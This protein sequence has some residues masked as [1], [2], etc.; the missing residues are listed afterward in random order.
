MSSLPFWGYGV[1]LALSLLLSLVLT[2]VAMNLAVRLGLL[3]HPGPSK[4]HSKAVPYLGGAAIV[5]SFAVIVLAATA[6]RPPPTGF[7]QLAAL[8]GI[9]VLLAIVGLLDDIRGGLSP[10]LRLA[11]EAGAGAAVWSMGFAAHIPGLPNAA[12]AVV[13]VLWV[14]GVT[15]AFNLL[16]NMDGLSA[17]VAAVAALAIF[18]IA[19]AQHRYLV[20]AL[21]MALAGCAA[22]F[23]RHNFHPARIYMGD[24]GSLFLGFMLSVLLLKLRTEA[25]TRVEIA[26]IL[27]VPGVALFDTTLVMVSRVTHRRNPFNGGQDHTSH[28]LVYCGLSVRQAVGLTYLTGA[29]LGG[30]AITMTQFP[31]ARIVGVVGLL[32]VAALA[33]VPLY[34][35][36]VY[37]LPWAQ[38]KGLKVSSGA[39]AGTSLGQDEG[40]SCS[41]E[42]LELPEPQPEPVPRTPAKA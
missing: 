13:T 34:R 33:A 9:A 36:P 12:D 10:W 14:A 16:D 28:R 2:P 41:V 30:A 40:G 23:L 39:G 7:P 37:K 17:G 31:S 21:A 6:L 22:G 11:L 29:V 35:V 8:L 24:A 27:A 38:A 4:G 15:N 19:W 26:V 42:D 5:V 32:V 20:A 1:V 3:D 25:P 18:G